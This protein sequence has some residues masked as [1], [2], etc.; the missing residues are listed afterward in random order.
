MKI[1]GDCGGRT[2]IVEMTD[3]EFSLCAGYRNYSDF[4]SKVGLLAVGRD[5]PIGEIAEQLNWVRSF[6]PTLEQRLTDTRAGLLKADQLIAALQA[7][8]KVTPPPQATQAEVTTFQ[9]SRAIIRD[10]DETTTGPL[11]EV[12][13]LD[14]LDLDGVIGG[15]L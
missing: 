3:N 1:I 12:A 13:P 11:A 14:D 4:E 6:M 7:L 10:D 9:G 2:K 5:M 8:E 15:G